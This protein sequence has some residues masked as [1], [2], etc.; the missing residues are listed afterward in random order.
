ML[1]YK[2]R[3]SLLGSQGMAESPDR[4]VTT[5]SC[6]VG[7]SLVTSSESPPHSQSVLLPCLS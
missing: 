6:N 5:A 3:L 1:P 2:M 4:P 7:G